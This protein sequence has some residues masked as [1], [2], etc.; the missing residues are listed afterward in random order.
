MP[1]LTRS[2]PPPPPPRSRPKT[3]QSEKK[4]PPLFPLELFKAKML[5]PSPRPESGAL[6]ARLGAGGASLHTL[7]PTLC[8][9]FLECLPEP[10]VGTSV[11]T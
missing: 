4:A 5:C 9:S 6:K 2:R 7:I 1:S 10:S 3:L 11:Y 8:T